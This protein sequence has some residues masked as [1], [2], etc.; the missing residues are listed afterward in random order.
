MKRIIPYWDGVTWRVDRESR[1][2]IGPA[3]GAFEFDDD[4]MTMD[5]ARECAERAAAAD[6]RRI[7]EGSEGE[8]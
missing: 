7:L 3:F 5:Q 2:R 6:R 8:A 1:E 4:D